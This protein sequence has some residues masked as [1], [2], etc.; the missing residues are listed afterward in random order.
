MQVELHV[1]YNSY[2]M[3]VAGVR[4]QISS[5]SIPTRDATQVLYP[6]RGS[7]SLRLSKLPDHLVPQTR[8]HMSVDHLEVSLTPDQVTLLGNVLAYQKYAAPEPKPS[9][10]ACLQ[11]ST[12]P[13]LVRSSSQ[14][15]FT[16]DHRMGVSSLGLPIRLDS[17]LAYSMVWLS[18]CA[19]DERA[20]SGDRREA[21]RAGCHI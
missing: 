10:S 12:G 5:A 18:M 3:S 16:F 6:F 14:D 19:G 7:A 13:H 8:L 17:H 4:L 11:S 15:F 20:Q 2:Q 1:L 21:G 9:A